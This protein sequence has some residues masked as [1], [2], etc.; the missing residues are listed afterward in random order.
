MR[1]G[2]FDSRDTD[3]VRLHVNGEPHELSGQEFQDWLDHK[4]APDVLKRLLGTA[5]ASQ[6]I[7]VALDPF[8]GVQASGS[9]GDEPLSP[10]FESDGYMTVPATEV[11]TALSNAFPEQR[12]YLVD[13]PEPSR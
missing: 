1:F 13:D 8:S 6:P 2:L 11:I 9:V 3:V 12:F 7:F 4:A 10:Y 5:R